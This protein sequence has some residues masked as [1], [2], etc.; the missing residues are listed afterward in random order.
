[1]PD[2]IIREFLVESH[3]SLDRLDVT[4]VELERDPRN[5]EHLASV[6]R[7]IHTIKGTCGF[8]GFTTLES[9]AHAGESLLSHLRDGSIELDQDVTSGLLALVDA[10]RNLLVSIEETGQDGDFD[11][12][13]LV[14]RLERLDTPRPRREPA[15]APSGPVPGDRRSGFDRRSGDDRRAGVADSSLRVDVGQLD[16]LMTL[17]GELVLARNQIVQL[18]SSIRNAAFAAATERLTLVTADLQE[19][20]MKTRMQP[21]D[22]VWGKFPRVVRDLAL[23]CGKR[24]RV[25]MAGGDTDLD[26]AI[27]EAIKDPLTHAVR[28]AV[29]HG[30]EPPD[31]REARGKDPE[32]C[33]VLRAFQEGGQIAIEIADD[34][35]GI[36]PERVRRTA[37]ERGV[38]GAE[39]AGRL[40]DREVIDLVF[41]PGFSTAGRISNVSGRGVGMDVVKTNVERIGGTVEIR[42]KPGEG[43]TLRINLPLTLAIIPAL[44]I[45]TGGERFAIPQVNVVEAVRLEGQRARAGLDQR[46]GA[47][48][49]RLRGRRLP[50]LHLHREL[51]LASMA[52]DDV[53]NIVVVRADD[54]QFGLVVDAVADSEELV[55]KPMGAP[56]SGGDVFAGTA[57]MGDGRVALVL[58]VLGLARRLQPVPEPVGGAAGR[59][60]RY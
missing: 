46:N 7:T 36:D 9:I 55:V 41:V 2:D 48:F 27:V 56:C 14:A 31:V 32:G 6:F 16:R 1:M 53:V 50:V 60:R 54:R 4:L 29:D 51:E 39:A 44:T 30:I 26:K 52:D 45:A 58:D 33:I 28:N 12:A 42:S 11:C 20:V 21:I 8:L 37:V 19:A 25:E 47:T 35:G 10:I 23:A 43:T 40:P 57:T 59:G 3:E 38:V 13:D 49:H 34:G 15:A 24:V 18:A 17:V 5:I 22:S